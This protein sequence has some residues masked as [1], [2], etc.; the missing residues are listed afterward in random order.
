MKLQV[1]ILQFYWKKGPMQVFFDEFCEIFKVPFLQ[2]TS[3]RLLL[4]YG[5]LFYHEKSKE[6]SEK[7]KKRRKLLVKK[8]NDAHIK[9]LKHY[10]HQVLISFYY[11]KISLFL[12]YL[13]LMIHWNMVS[14]NGKTMTCDYD[15]KY[16]FEKQCNLTEDLS[17]IG[18]YFSTSVIW[19]WFQ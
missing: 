3:R 2:D 9:K 13:L 8:N 10:L 11:S 1:C 4:F 19:F 12:I 15:W 17:T 18:K 6:P 16:L 14:R 5:K 7:R